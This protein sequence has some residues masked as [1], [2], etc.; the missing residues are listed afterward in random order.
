MDSKIFKMFHAMTANWAPRIV[1]WFTTSATP[2]A[3]VYYVVPPAKMR[4]AAVT[5]HHTTV[6]D[7]KSV[8]VTKATFN[9]SATQL[10]TGSLVLSTDVTGTALA[11]VSTSAIYTQTATST[12]SGL[13]YTIPQG[14]NWTDALITIDGTHPSTREA[15]KITMPTDSTMTTTYIELSWLPV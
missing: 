7:S 4:L 10:P 9:P 5:V 3:L 12:S 1:N 6:A 13:A 15:I 14:S 11:D 2:S 8:A